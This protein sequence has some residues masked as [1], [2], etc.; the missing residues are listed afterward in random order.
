MQEVGIDIVSDGGEPT[1]WLLIW[2]FSLLVVGF[3]FAARSRFL[4]GQSGRTVPIFSQ[5]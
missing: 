3:V 2:L 5:D 1:P 4:K